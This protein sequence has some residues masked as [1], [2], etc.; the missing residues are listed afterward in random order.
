MNVSALKALST[1]QMLDISRR[2][3][4]E[5]R[6][7]LHAITETHGALTL[8]ERTHRKLEEASSQN[9]EQ[10]E[11]MRALTLALGKLDLVHDRRVRGIYHMLT[12]LGESLDDEQLARRYVALRDLLLPAGLNTTLMR[13]EEQIRAA[14]EVREHLDATQRELLSWVELPGQQGTLLDQVELWWTSASDLDEVW[15]QRQELRQHSGEHASA[16]DLLRARHQWIG[17]LRVLA[18][19]LEASSLSHDEIAALLPETQTMR[20]T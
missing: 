2:C 12:A 1:A 5:Q 17:A 18:A 13:Y 10:G 19:S 16:G 7:A 15:Q 4:V 3:L 14:F 8:L 20:Q 11:A 9:P 6:A